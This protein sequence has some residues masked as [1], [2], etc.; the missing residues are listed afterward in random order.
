MLCEYFIFF[1]TFPSLD[2][3][4]L[5]WQ[6]FV[7]RVVECSETFRTTTA[8]LDILYHIL[9]RRTRLSAVIINNICCYNIIPTHAHM[10][11]ASIDNV[12]SMLCAYIAVKERASRDAAA[13]DAGARDFDG[14]WRSR[15]NVGESYEK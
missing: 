4:L 15:V 9:E 13:V 10:R 14:C 7:K 11:T 8:G 2:P 6:P 12:A 1:K 5:D 3:R